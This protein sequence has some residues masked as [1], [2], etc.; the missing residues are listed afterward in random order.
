MASYCAAWEPLLP[1]APCCCPT[2]P[3][4]HFH[5]LSVQKGRDRHVVGSRQPEVPRSPPV[6]APPT[7]RD[8]HPASVLR[9]PKGRIAPPPWTSP[10]LEGTQPEPGR[11][12]VVGQQQSDISRRRREWCVLRRW[13]PCRRC[14]P[15]PSGSEFVGCH[16]P[17]KFSYWSG[18]I[19]S[20]PSGK[21]IDRMVLL[22]D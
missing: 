18:R 17:V 3:P 19:R 20:K 15:V 9:L 2:V 14:Q 6:Q 12:R 21:P 16:L 5:S 8:A 22:I 10:P 11:S 1:G 7:N 4:T 13:C